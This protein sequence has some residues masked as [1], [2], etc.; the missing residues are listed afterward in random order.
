MLARVLVVYLVAIAAGE[1]LATFVSPVSGALL[2]AMLIWLILNHYVL[3]LPGPDAVSRAVGR[4]EI[5]A[6]PVLALVPLLRLVS[7]ATP[8]KE[9]PE[10]YWPAI[11]G[12]PVLLAAV[13]VVR[14]LELP[15]AQIGL[16]VA[17][18]RAQVAIAAAGVPLGLVAFLI[19]RP[20]QPAG[21]FD[22]GQLALRAFILVVFAVVTEEL[23]FRGLV[24]RVFDGFLG[25]PGFVWST[26][27]S[28]LV[29]L[30]TQAPGYIAFIA[31]MGMFFGWCAQST[32]SIVGVTVAH[33]ALAVG[34]VVVWPYV[35]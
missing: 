33:S 1:A 35:L 12:G 17:S 13:L 14:S 27:L 29:Y 20:P 30:G 2:D 4:T 19:Q 26:G 18:W 31:A 21:G 10:T 32:H 9:V 16:C 6:L 28:T 24:Q 3:L 5:A 8:L 25:R 11:V 7:L 22:G 23:I 34:L 15:R